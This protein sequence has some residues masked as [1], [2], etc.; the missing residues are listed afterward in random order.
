MGNR[1]RYEKRASE[2]IEYLLSV[3]SNVTDDNEYLLV[4]CDMYSPAD[5]G[6]EDL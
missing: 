3:L 1:V 4:A 6:E 2:E 5:F